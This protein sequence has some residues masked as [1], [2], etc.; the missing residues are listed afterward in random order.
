MN[1]D[2]SGFA[3]Y[4]D[5]ADMWIHESFTNYSESLFLE[6]YYGKELDILMLEVLEI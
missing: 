2:T 6:Y 5:I 1:R 3:T 4:K